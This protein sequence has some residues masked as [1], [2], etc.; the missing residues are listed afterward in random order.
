MRFRR[1]SELWQLL[2][3][4][5]RIAAEWGH[6][7][8]PGDGV[9]LVRGYPCRD[10]YMSAPMLSS[11]PSRMMQLSRGGELNLESNTCTDDALFR[12]LRGCVWSGKGRFNAQ[13]KNWTRVI[14]RRRVARY[15]AVR[16][17]LKSSDAPW[18]GRL[19]QAASSDS[20]PYKALPRL[21]ERERE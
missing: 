6:R 5:S 2:V 8:E 1:A 18:T 12:R 19:L 15:C 14:L 21:Q 9:G 10:A 20:L 17:S 13:Q 16:S 3:E 7:G 4:A 11:S